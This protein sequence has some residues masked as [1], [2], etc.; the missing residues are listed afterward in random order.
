MNQEESNIKIIV[1][2]D[3]RETGLFQLC[4][5]IFSKHPHSNEINVVSENLPIGDI[6]I[7]DNTDEKIIIERKTLSDLAASIKDGRYTEQSYRLDGISHHNHNIIYLIEGDMSKYNIFKAHMDKETLYSAMFSIN[8]YKG[9]S[10]MRSYSID[11]TALMICNMVYKILKTDK[12]SYYINPKPKLPKSTTD[13]TT[14]DVQENNN[15][16]EEQEEEQ[17]QDTKNYCKVV[18][19]VK[20]DNITAENIGEIMLCQIPS[21]S[22]VTALAVLA[23]FG[24]LPKLIMAIQQDENCLKDISSTNTKGQVR[25]ISKSCIQNIIQFLK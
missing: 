5:N 24:T 12:P 22:S 6:I 21:V 2:I 14:T 1:K 10:V 25:K 16:E 7:A 18:K 19:K 17:Q 8:Y 3:M 11:E 20:K 15:V 9:F 23:K 13:D 4:K